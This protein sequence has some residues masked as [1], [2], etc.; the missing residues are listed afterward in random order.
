VFV[1]YF[2]RNGGPEA[3][4]GVALPDWSQSKTAVADIE[5][6]QVVFNGDGVLSAIA[7]PYQAVASPVVTAVTPSGASAGQS[8]VINGQ[9][10]TGT[11]VS[12]GVKFGG[13][14]ATS[15]T[16]VNDQLIT[17]VLPAGSAGPAAVTVQNANGTSN[18]FAYARGA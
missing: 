1:R 18:S 4:A 3:Y 12:T 11:V 15:F 16:V 8:V 2:D 17:A 13:T 10:F 6:I 7:N 14:A 9:G 5:E